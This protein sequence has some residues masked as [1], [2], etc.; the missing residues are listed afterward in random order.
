MCCS[1]FQPNGELEKLHLA[2]Q[3]FERF[4]LVRSWL[5]PEH[6]MTNHDLISLLTKRNERAELRFQRKEPAHS[7]F[8]ATHGPQNDF[9]AVI[10]QTLPASSRSVW[11]LISSESGLSIWLRPFAPFPWKV[12]QA[13][14][15]EGGIFGEIR[16]LKSGH[17]ARLTWQ[18]ADWEKPSAL[19]IHLSQR[20]SRKCAVT[21]SH[22]KIPTARLKGRLSD[23]WKKALR[24]LGAAI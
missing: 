3:Q 16:S 22:E 7:A 1:P 12:G 20:A 6:N 10:S 2:S 11:K 14:E 4:L 9:S 8:P 23:Q 5:Y 21:I 17:R 24:E 15:V 13:Y 19:Q 18:E